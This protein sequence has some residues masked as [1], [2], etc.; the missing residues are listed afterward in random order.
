MP[1]PRE[2]PLDISVIQAVGRGG[3]MDHTLQK[4]TE[5]GASAFQP[6]WAERVEVR[7]KGDK[8]AKKRLHWQGVVISA[9]EQSGRAVVPEVRE[10]LGITD[11]GAP[12]D[13]IARLVLDPT[14]E[15]SLASVGGVTSLQLV[16]GPEGGLT[17]AELSSLVQAGAIPVSLGPRVL[18]TETAAPAALAVLQALLG[19]FR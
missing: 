2:P 12:S 16:V 14:A 8:L 9:C 4:C 6:L 19:D 15:R 5:L 18:R 3:R 7:L 17:D 13:G 10:P 11:L 1:G